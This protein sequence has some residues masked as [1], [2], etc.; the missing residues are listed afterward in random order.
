VEEERRFELLGRFRPAVFKVDD[1]G[2]RTLKT[3]AKAHVSHR[4]ASA[5]ERAKYADAGRRTK[6]ADKTTAV[7]E[8]AVALVH[9]AAFDAADR[10]ALE[11]EE[12][13]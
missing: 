2:S 3:A 6:R 12:G 5:T 1:G 11:L 13:E 8:S 9:L 7:V 10:F 4:D